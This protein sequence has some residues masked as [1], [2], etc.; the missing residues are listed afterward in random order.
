MPN[1]K[2]SKNTDLRLAVDPD[3]R[4]LLDREARRRGVQRATLFEQIISAGLGDRDDF[5]RGIDAMKAA[6]DRMNTASARIDAI[7]DL[8]VDQAVRLK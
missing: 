1:T 3:V 4:R 7:A 2:T 5:R 8:I 6:T